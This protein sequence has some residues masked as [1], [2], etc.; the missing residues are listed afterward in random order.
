MPLLSSSLRR[1]ATAHEHPPQ[2][3]AQSV[4]E[5]PHAVAALR[6][7]A[8]RTRPRLVRPSLEPFERRVVHLIQ[9]AQQRRREV[10]QRWDVLWLARVREAAAR[11]EQHVRC[12]RART[13]VEL[14]RARNDV[15]VVQ[16]C[17]GGRKAHSEVGLGV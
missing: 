11:V 10:L 13:R 15:V 9:L 7:T 3:A 8:T 14:G 5:C 4:R 6:A 1:A 2:D 12:L 17:R 16:P